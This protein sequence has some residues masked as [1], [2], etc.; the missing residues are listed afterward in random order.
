MVKIIPPL[1]CHFFYLKPNSLGHMEMNGQ[2]KIK[3]LHCFY[4]E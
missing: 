3:Q 2:Q 1:L 4:D